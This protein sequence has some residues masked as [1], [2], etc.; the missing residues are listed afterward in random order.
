MVYP[1]TCLPYGLRRRMKDAFLPCAVYGLIHNNSLTTRSVLLFSSIVFFYLYYSNFV[2][3]HDSI[4]PYPLAKLAYGLRRRLGQLCTPA[5]RYNLQV[6]AGQMSICPPK[7]QRITPMDNLVEFRME[8]SKFVV[9]K[10]MDNQNKRRF[11]VSKN[12]LY[13]CKTDILFR[14]MRFQNLK[15]PIFS[16]NF[17]FGRGFT[18]YFFDCDNSETFYQKVAAVTKAAPKQLIIHTFK[19]LVVSFKLLF[20]AFPTTESLF[21]QGI[22]QDGW[23]S[24]LV[25]HQKRK[26]TLCL[27]FGSH[28]TIGAFT[29]REVTALLKKQESNF[30][31]G[32]NFWNETR[33]YIKQVKRTLSQCLSRLEDPNQF[34]RVSIKYGHKNVHFA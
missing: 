33:P 23:M 13:F 10:T 34:A 4:M 29:S 14:D 21:L 20:A 2:I 9:L 16:N 31:L 18:I 27:V 1:I 7:L 17:V 24:N 19:N 6:A 5:E 3:F 25:H 12:A 30:Q 26:L 28:E 32:V 11:C 22:L 15:A 8:N